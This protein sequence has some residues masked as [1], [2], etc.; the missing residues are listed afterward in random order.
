MILN[1]DS[2]ALPLADGSVDCVV[3][4]PP[5]GLAFMGKDWDKV[6]P[7]VDIWREVLRVMKPGAFAAILCTPRQDCQARMILN[8]EEAGFVTG[9]TSIMWTY[10]TGF[11]K[12]ASLSKLADKRAGVERE[13]VGISVRPDGSRR[14]NTTKNPGVT[15]RCGSNDKDITLPATPEAKALD[16]AYAGWQPKPAF[17]PVLIVMKPLTEKTYLDQALA[18]GHGCSWLDDGR[19]PTGDESIPCFDASRTDRF[20]DRQP[21]TI[22][23]TGE[24]RSNG[25]FPANVLCS[26]N[27][28]NDGRVTRGSDRPRKKFDE[29]GL[30]TRQKARDHGYRPY[31]T[32][33]APPFTTT[34]PADSGS[35]SRYFDLDAWFSERIKSLPA[36]VQR[37]YPWLIVPK[38]SKREKNA[39]LDR[40]PVTVDDGRHTPIDNPFLRGE[41]P[42]TNPHPTCKP[43]KLMSYL[44]T[45]FSRPGDIVLDP[46]V[47]S[48]T[49]AVS[50]EI[51]AREFIGVELSPEYAQIAHHRALYAME[52]DSGTMAHELSE[53][54]AEEKPDPR[55]A[56]LFD[57]V[58]DWLKG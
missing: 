24:T 51:M 35:Y 5:Y 2:S 28:L 33:P 55:Q 16:G 21:T 49:T 22:K 25:R 3:T 13:V 10:A 27:C 6:V 48:G 43:V 32:P 4:D 47:G 8:L 36:E 30:G 7:P 40:A 1:G 37:V 23:R 56:S 20:I 9:F 58:P 52:H 34:G 46:F 38:P 42:R 45:L 53:R 19:I 44:I 39:G 29:S 41:T 31:R 15:F 57:T 17:E 50:A 12:A 14:I 18:N 54:P 11:P 26:D